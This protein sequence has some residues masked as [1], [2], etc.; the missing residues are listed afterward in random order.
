M[1]R[2][3]GFLRRF[4]GAGAPGAASAVGVPADRVA[5][6]AAEL[7]PVF[8]RLAP[9]QAAAEA[10]RDRAR[11]DAERSRRHAEEQAA[12]VLTAARETAEAERVAASLA[13]SRRVDDDRERT[14]AAADEQAERVRR[15]AAAVMAQYVERVLAGVRSALDDQPP[16]DRRRDDQPGAPVP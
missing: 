15:H 7:E 3:R 2:T 5:E 11:V 6:T 9:F 13:A 12:A 4:R 8:A 1:P 14:L 10:I 16:D